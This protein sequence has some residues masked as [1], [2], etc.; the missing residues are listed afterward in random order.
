LEFI[1]LMLAKYVSEVKF[2]IKM[3]DYSKMFFIEA[4]LLKSKEDFLSFQVCVAMISCLRVLLVFMK[5]RVVKMKRALQKGIG[6]GLTSG[7]IT[8]I[9]L[10]VGLYSGTH[11]FLAVVGGM[12]SVAI[13]DSCSDALGIHVSEE[14]D[15]NRTIQEVW[16]ATLSAFLVK[17]ILALIFLVPVFL[18]PL[19]SAIVIN[20]TLGAFL[21]SLFSYYIAQ[22]RGVRA[23]KVIVEHLVIMF[24][25]VVITHF[26]GIFI[27]RTLG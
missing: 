4:H 27:S 1:Y 13:A 24:S 22:E 23:W 17:F 16:V 21:L 14:V 11:S 2:L 3:F 8:T 6:F 20:I 7:I 25:V 19:P 26:V 15:N 10:M 18:F 9:G 12:L 5:K